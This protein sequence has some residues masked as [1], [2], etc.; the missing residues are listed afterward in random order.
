[1]INPLTKLMP[2]IALI[3]LGC[4]KK[5]DKK[6][7]PQMQRQSENLDQEP[8]PEMYVPEYETSDEFFTK[9]SQIYDGGNAHGRVRI[10]YSKNIE[11]L[12]E[13]EM[14]TVPVG[15][16]S[17]KQGYFNE[18]DQYQKI[19]TMIKRAP[20]YDPENHDWEYEVRGQDGTLQQNGKLA[21]CIGC[22]SHAP[23]TD[24]LMGSRVSN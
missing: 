5:N 19:V 23:E 13:E 15:T 14:Y 12:I 8:G 24:F 4:G 9:T 3:A 1:M 7:P 21:G 17:I 6:M 10:W 16:V 22:H 20:G 11:S 2:F 18:N